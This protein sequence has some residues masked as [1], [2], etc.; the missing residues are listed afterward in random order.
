MIPARI[1]SPDLLTG[2]RPRLDRY[3]IGKAE[4]DWVGASDWS[5]RFKLLDPIGA[6]L[7]VVPDGSATQIRWFG[8]LVMSYLASRGFSLEGSPA[9]ERSRKLVR[10]FIYVQIFSVIFLEKLALHVGDGEIQ[11]V[12]PIFLGSLAVLAFYVPIYIDQVR[13]LAYAIFVFTALLGHTF[14]PEYSINSMMLVFVSYIGMC[15]Y[16]KADLDTFVKCLRFFNSCVVVVCVLTFYQVLTQYTIGNQ[17]WGNLEKIVPDWL[18]FS[19][20]NYLQPVRYLSPYFKPNAIFML[21]VSQISQF[22][23]MALMIEIAFFRRPLFTVLYASALM[24]TFSGVGLLVLVFC[25][26]ALFGNL[27]PRLLLMGL[28]SLAGA[29]LAAWLTGWSDVAGSRVLEFTTPGTSGYYRFNIPVVMF[30]ELIIDPSYLFAG[31]GAGSTSKGTAYLLLPFA[32]VISEY[33]ILTFFSFYLFL[34]VSLYRKPPSLTVSYT[35]FVLYNLAGSTLGMPMY[36]I[37]LVML[38]TF[39]RITS[40]RQQSAE[41]N[42][43][44]SWKHA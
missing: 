30:G 6:L 39:F 44:S 37:V 16:A 31:N 25:I 7:D 29:V 38:G 41:T 24:L 23:A 10:S 1:K 20:Y 43:L 15:V 32:K 40:S 21:E 33:G 5:I 19:G 28:L 2:S 35:A 36:V 3:K 8:K 22:S 42:A 4:T 27:S 12:L 26:P 18:L 13:L 17:Y 9:E 34:I 14:L 11:L